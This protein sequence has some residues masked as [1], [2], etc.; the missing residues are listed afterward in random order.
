MIDI[1]IESDERLKEKT[2]E[3]LVSIFQ[4]AGDL[5]VALAGEF[6][7]GFTS[8]NKAKFVL[9]F[10]NGTKFVEYIKIKGFKPEAIEYEGDDYMIT[11]YD[12]RV[13]Y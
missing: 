13:D 3:K 9:V 7:N 11:R 12:S 2:K 8:F 6:P 5:K 10:G 4:N 1:R